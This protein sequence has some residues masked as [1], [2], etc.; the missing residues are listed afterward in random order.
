[1]DFRPPI[2]QKKRQQTLILVFAGVMVLIGVVLWTGFGPSGV[3]EDSDSEV[4]DSILPVRPIVLPVG[5][6]ESPIFKDLEQLPDSTPSPEQTGR[7]N[8][9]LP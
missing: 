8:P 7:D 6:F 1:M 9:F 3:Q 4:R 2:Q 5:V